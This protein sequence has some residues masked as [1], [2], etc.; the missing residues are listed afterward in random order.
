MD[1]LKYANGNIPLSQEEKQKMKKFAQSF[2]AN[3]KDR[4][5]QT[6]RAVL[7]QKGKACHEAALYFGYKS[8]RR[9]ERIPLLCHKL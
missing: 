3:S 8:P 5:S 2:E 4:T 1:K 7:P 6:P 9:K